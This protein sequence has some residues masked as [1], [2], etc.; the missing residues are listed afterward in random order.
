MEEILYRYR[1]YDIEFIRGL[2]IIVVN[3][4]MLVKDFLEMKHLLSRCEYKIK[5][6]R[7]RS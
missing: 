4:P 7:V 3:K 6:I 1:K 5:D 2:G